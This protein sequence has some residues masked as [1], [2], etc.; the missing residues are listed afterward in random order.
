MTFSIIKQTQS[1][2]CHNTAVVIVNPSRVG[3]VL[4]EDLRQQA[5]SANRLSHALYDY[6]V[7]IGDKAKGAKLYLSLDLDV[8]SWFFRY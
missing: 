6:D 4:W 5:L 7:K 1:S 3:R 2:R 8:T